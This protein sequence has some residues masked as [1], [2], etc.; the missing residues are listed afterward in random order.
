MATKTYVV[1]WRL[2][3]EADNPAEA[4]RKHAEALEMMDDAPCEVHVWGDGPQEGRDRQRMT[5]DTHITYE[6]PPAPG[7]NPTAMQEA[8]ELGRTH[9]R[10]G[11]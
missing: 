2:V 3:I 4:R 1:Q 5:G 10:Q 8:Y 9:G 7:I 6:P 11:R